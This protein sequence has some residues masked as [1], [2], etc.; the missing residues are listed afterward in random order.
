MTNSASAA[1]QRTPEKG[2]RR[3]RLW[4]L[5]SWFTALS[6]VLII[7][8]LASAHW[9]YRYRV[10]KPMLQEVL[11]ARVA[12][13]HYHR[14]YFPNPGF[15]ATEITLD[16][17]PTPG[18]PTLGTIRSIFVQGN[19]LDLVMF[20][21]RVRKVDITG[22]HLIIPAPGSAA[23]KK[24]F[25]PGS[26]SSFS[27]PDTFIDELRIHDSTLDVIRA[28]GGTYT[29][30]ISMLTIRKLQKGRELFYSVDMDNARPRGHILSQGSFGPLNPRDLGATP[31]SGQFTFG[32]VNLHD[33][34]DISGTSISK[35]SF[36][37]NLA[38]IQ[39]EATVFT[40]DFAVDNGKPTPITT[41]AHCTI[42]ALNG[43]VMLDAIDTKS[44][45][46]IIHMQGGI[47]GSPK[48][49]DV[50]IDVVA[51][52]T[53]D[54]LRPFI[55]VDSPIAGVVW[56]KSHAHVDAAGNGVPFLDRLHVDGSFDVPAERLTDR[57]SEQELSAFSQRAQKNQPFKA[58]PAADSGSGG[59]AQSDTADVVSSLKG[60][61]R[62]ERGSVT[63]NRLEF[64]MPGSSMDLHG[65]FN[66][67]DGSAHLV[68]NLQMQSN[69]SNAATG[70][71]SFLL[72]PLIPF[73]KKKKAGAVIP[74]AVNGKPGNYQVSQDVLGTK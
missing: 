56:L 55:R 59:G 19:W 8:F 16:R 40:P 70:F 69:V 6:I 61:A 37:G 39:A 51:G 33:I 41:S 35:G 68:G 31:L 27:G 25:P 63:T 9:P 53:Q 13:A 34:G 38:R 30:P 71:K 50:D 42:N 1:V 26:S 64:Q 22:M 52:R 36:Q 67:H 73:F 28:E 5:V 4:H 74:I 2:S 12:I 54:I 47:A 10:I 45:S 32:Q 66:L 65:T 57:K 14:T 18:V 60:R 43:N 11:G 15:M 62:I 48:V 49:I 20:R 17:N 58:G 29:F 72:K 24:D 21:E 44:G 7:G 23:S 46:T 3:R